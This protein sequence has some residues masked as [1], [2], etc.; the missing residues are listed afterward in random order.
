MGTRKIKTKHNKKIVI[1][2]KTAII[3]IYVYNIIPA[4]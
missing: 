1:D 4:N 3:Y 2:E